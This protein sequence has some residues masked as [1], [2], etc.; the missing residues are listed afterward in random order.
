[1]PKLV[2]LDAHVTLAQ[3]LADEDGPVIL[4]NT[5]ASRRRKRTPCSR[6]G[7]RTQPS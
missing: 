5:S 1:M 3:Q 4:I 2:E 6:P 7:R